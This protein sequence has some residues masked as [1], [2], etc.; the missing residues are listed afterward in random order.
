MAQESFTRTINVRSERPHV[1]DVLT[2]VETLAGW[3]G[4]VHSVSEL[5]HL[6]RY[7]AVLQDKV[8]PFKLRA[9]LAI[10][11][12]VEEDGRRVSVS[13]A[14][15]D[16]AVDSRIKVDAVLD[17]GEAQDGTAINVEGTYQVTG[18]VATMGGG[19]IR[20]KA[21]GILDDFFENAAGALNPAAMNGQG[22]S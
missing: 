21:D 8:G 19:I 15:R 10:S 2:D 20:K 14:G 5:Q 18:K 22:A 11:V 12:T 4:I 1:W 6:E 7:R 9:D 3:V 13:A 17:L 16:R